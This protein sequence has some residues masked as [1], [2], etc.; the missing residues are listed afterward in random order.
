MS[1]RITFKLYDRDAAGNSIDEER[2]ALA[3]QHHCQRNLGINMDL[4]AIVKHVFLRYL[5]DNV[6]RQASAPAD[7]DKAGVAE[8]Q[9]VKQETADESGTSDNPG[10]TESATVESSSVAADALADT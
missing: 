7:L 9:V 1:R 6:D 2:L 5:R 10:D 8:E 4:N 3:F